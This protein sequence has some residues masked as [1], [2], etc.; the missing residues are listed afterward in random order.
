MGKKT[1]AS[2]KKRGSGVKISVKL[3]AT[4]FIVLVAILT[5]NTFV[6]TQTVRT[7]ITQEEQETLIQAATEKANAMEQYLEDQ[8]CLA[9]TLRNDATYLEAAMAV[10][11]GQAF[12]PNGQQTVANNLASIFEST[13]NVYE[14]FFVTVGTQGYA[15]CLGNAT[16]H[17]VAEENFYIQCQENGYYFGNNVSPVTGRPVYVIAYAVYNPND[18]SQMIGSINMSIDMESMGAG[19]IASDEYDITVLDSAGV[20]IASNR[21]ETT[22]YILSDMSQEQPEG[23]QNMI[24]TG[25]GCNYLD[26]RAYGKDE[27]YLAYY[28]SDNFIVQVSVSTASVK[29]SANEMA[30]KMATMAAVMAVI[31][32]LILFVVITWIVRPLKIATKAVQKLSRDLGNGQGDLTHKIL[33]NSRDEIGIMVNGIN[34]MMDAM[35]GIIS[36]VQTTTNGVTTSSS[37]INSQIERAEMEI[38][39]VSSTMEQMSASSEETSASLT[40]VLVQVD[41]VA[42]LVEEMNKTSIQNADYAEEVVQK[43]KQIQETSIVTREEANSHL[44]EVA[45]RLREKIANAKQVEEIANLTDEILNITSQTNLLSL[46]ASIEAARAGEAGKGFAVVADEIRQLAD[47]SKEAANR[48]QDVTASVIVAV[49]DLANEAGNV[50]EFMVQNNEETHKET[51]ELTESYSDDISKLADSMSG[52]KESS[53]VIQNSMDVIR[54][55]IDAVNR[56]AEETANGIT[57]VARATIDLSGELQQVLDHATDNVAETTSLSAEINKFK[58]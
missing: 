51:D 34:D 25:S 9:M 1:N 36:S 46:N 4:V 32:L 27:S 22:D 44:Q 8:K 33:V 15:D 18:S 7:K 49:E 56:A 24:A 30:I 39:N 54:D 20:I 28:V 48:I 16:L 53:D 13:G 38:S 43:V 3:L 12:D 37:D 11:Q 47:S 42:G 17:D 58:V 5:I 35:S 40:Q 10:A 29:K 21:E 14:N 41:N 52:F 2:K 23:Y 6:A 26:L 19:I 57:N 50:T 45:D 55:A 31:A